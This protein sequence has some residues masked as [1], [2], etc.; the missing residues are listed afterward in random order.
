MNS[1]GVTGFA[2]VVIY[3]CCR[4]GLDAPLAVL[5]TSGPTHAV[6]PFYDWLRT[7]LLVERLGH[8]NSSDSGRLR[9]LSTNVRCHKYVDLSCCLSPSVLSAP[10]VSQR[11]RFF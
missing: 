1:F 7:A 4:L 2:A 9:S 11:T 5:R 6:A 10:P 8:E 3:Y